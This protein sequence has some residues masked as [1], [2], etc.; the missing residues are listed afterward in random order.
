MTTAA[1]I[2]EAAADGVSLALSSAGTIKATGDQV[3]VNRWLPV[4]REHKPAILAAL[5]HP[6]LSGLSPKLAARLSVEDLKDIAAAVLWW[7]VSITEPGGRVV[8]VDTPSGYT[9]ADWQAYADRY[10]GPGCS[11]TP[12]AGLPKTATLDG[13]SDATAPVAKPR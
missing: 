1:I 12:I 7:R 4:L 11:V 9:L 6:D 13:P 10:H 5:A 3:A 8:E 2:R